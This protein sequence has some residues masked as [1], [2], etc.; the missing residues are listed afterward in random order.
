MQAVVVCGV[1]VVAGHNLTEEGTKEIP[2]AEVRSPGNRSMLCVAPFAPEVVS[3][4]AVG[5][6][7]GLTVGV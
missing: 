2:A 4:S 6:V 1:V 3:G 7:G 5:G